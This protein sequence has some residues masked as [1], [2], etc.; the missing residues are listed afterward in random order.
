MCH[1]LPLMTIH[2]QKCTHYS[3]GRGDLFS[4]SS[5]DTK[6]LL[7]FS[8]YAFALGKPIPIILLE[9]KGLF[10]FWAKPTKLAVLLIS[11]FYLQSKI[12]R[13]PKLPN[14]TFHNF[15]GDSEAPSRS[16][17]MFFETLKF[18]KLPRYQQCSP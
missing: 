8:L 14:K 13:P 1:Y 2:P 6:T 12:S 11:T 17:D 16:S 9:T 15:P 10:F 3:R 5:R 4:R 7:S 18:T